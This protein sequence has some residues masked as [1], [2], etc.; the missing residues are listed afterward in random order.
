M[1]PEL[2][3]LPP[4]SRPSSAWHHLSSRFTALVPSGQQQTPRMPHAR[5]RYSRLGPTPA[6]DVG[7]RSR[8]RG[9]VISC[10]VPV[11]PETLLVCSLHGMPASGGVQPNG[12]ERSARAA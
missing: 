3:E 5:M 11:G 6:N 9:E 12:S 1:V 2:A 7:N 10:L 4:L 8:C